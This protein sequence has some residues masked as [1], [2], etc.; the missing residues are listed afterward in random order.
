MR[1]GILTAVFLA[2]STLPA[3]GSGAA[4]AGTDTA[5][6]SLRRGRMPGLHSDHDPSPGPLERAVFTR[7]CS[8][9]RGDTAAR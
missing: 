2:A 7:W 8:L 4:R 1:P 6:R 9:S 5:S 3:C